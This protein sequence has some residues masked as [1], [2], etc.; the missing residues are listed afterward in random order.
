MRQYVEQSLPTSLNGCLTGA[1]CTWKSH[2]RAA[3]CGAGSIAT[4]EER[5]GW[6]GIYPEV[7]L[8][9]ARTKHLEARKVL[10]AG[11]DPG[12]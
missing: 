3:N 6:L 12:E 4:P 5:K 2:L 1:V 7:G 11:I 10:N 9:E 8:A